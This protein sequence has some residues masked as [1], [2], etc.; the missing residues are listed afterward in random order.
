MT[1]MNS[2]PRNIVLIGYDGA[3]SLDLVGP[4]EVFA[5]A[6]RYAGAQAY[7]I[8]LA[9]LEGGTI[10]CNSGLRLADFTPIFISGW[11]EKTDF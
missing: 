10:T 11:H 7:N 6:N 2:T 8:I 4:L 9:S 3:Q 1:S 5:M